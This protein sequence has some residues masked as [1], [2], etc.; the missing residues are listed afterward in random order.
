MMRLRTAVVVVAAVLLTI[1]AGAVTAPAA[2]APAPSEYFAIHVVDEQTGR[3]V[4]LVELKTTHDVRHVTDSNGLIAFLEPGLMD[5][6]V[7]FHVASHGYEYPKDGFGYRGVRLKPTAGGAATVKIKRVNVAERLYRITGGGIYRDTILLGRKPPTSRP[8]IN[9]LVLGQDSVQTCAYRG[10]MWWF[11]GDTNQP[12]YPLGNFHMSGATSSLT[13]DGDAGIDLA[14]FVN[15]KGFSRDMFPA[16]EEGP[17]WADAFMV[18]P[19]EKGRERMICHFVRV[20]GLEAR[21]EQGL[22][23]FNDDKGIIERWHKLDV[24]DEVTPRGHPLRVKVDGVDY[25]YFLSPYPNIRVKADIA[26]IRD[27]AQYE[28]FTFLKPGARK[29]DKSNP[30]LDRDASGKLR[31]AWKRNTA[32]VSSADQA[33]LER[34]GLLNADQRWARPRDIETG[35]PVD[36]HGG[37][38]YWNEF[39]RKYVMIFVQFMGS[40]LVG[41]VWYAEADKPEGPWPSAR[42]IVTHDNYSFYNPKHHPFLDA[43]G[44]RVIYFEGTYTALFTDNKHPTPRYDYNQIMYR[45]D[46]A[47]PRLKLAK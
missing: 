46:L 27:R 6:E 42:K 3:G 28:T 17:I 11:W 33:E 39:R 43:D 15:D 36:I 23:I 22:G 16:K 34:R 8:V 1:A 12:A 31:H 38:V 10:K 21:L 13:P 47:D 40:S 32:L 35:K 44:G 41:E 25:F 5:T 24:N 14:Y 18:L 45:L 26:S 37:S 7:F 2:P 20:R 4:P 30:Q 19:D 29:L 9:G